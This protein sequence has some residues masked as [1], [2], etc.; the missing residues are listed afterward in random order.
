MSTTE[1]PNFDVLLTKEEID[2][3]I[4]QTAETLVPML[5]GKSW[6]AIVILL[7]AAP[8]ASDLLRAL[9]DRGIDV[10]FDA[11]WLESY[12]DAR[13]SSGRVVVRADIQRSIAGRGA[14]ILDDVFD[15]GRTLEFAR[16]HLMAK[17]AREVRT[18]VFA[19]K[20]EAA[21]T[22]LDA[23]AYDAPPRYLVGYGMDD[24]GHWRGLSYLGAVPE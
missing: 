20:P 10:G 15:S 22:G 16:T 18:C 12:R 7:G 4:K 17:G 2:A 5:E 3:R 24:A 6:T 9:A 23:W 21:P 11:L 13:E 19:R 14:L 1:I 8:F